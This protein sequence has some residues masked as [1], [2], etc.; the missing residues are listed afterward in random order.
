MKN[1]MQTV[2]SICA[3]VLAALTDSA[4][5]FRWNQQISSTIYPVVDWSNA[6]RMDAEMMNPGSA[7]RTAAREDGGKF[8]AK[9][10]RPDCHTGRCRDC[11]G[12]D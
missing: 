2:V 3:V 4:D 9:R 11:R 8:K 12:C 1:R 6:A 10:V 7:L 5:T